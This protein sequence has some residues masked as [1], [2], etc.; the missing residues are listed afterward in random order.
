MHNTAQVQ[1]Q[2][3]QVPLGI[4]RVA[5]MDKGSHKV[6]GCLCTER[7]NMADYSKAFLAVTNGNSDDLYGRGSQKLT[8][9]IE[10]Y[11]LSSIVA[12]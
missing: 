7:Y 6:S 5:H 2:S 10:K 3:Q 8:L 9:V 1:V 4:E 12:D 11:R